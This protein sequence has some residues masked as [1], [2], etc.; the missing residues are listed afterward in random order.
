MNMSTH[1]PNVI[2]IFQLVCSSYEF[3]CGHVTSRYF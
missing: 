1:A 2:V 3:E